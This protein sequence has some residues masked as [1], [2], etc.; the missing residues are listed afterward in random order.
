MPTPEDSRTENTL[1]G[2]ERRQLD[3]F[4]DDN[5]EELVEAVEGLTDEQA[6]RRLVPSLTTPMALVKH[7]AAAERV[8]FQKSLAGRSPEEIDGLADG[9]D[10][11]FELSDDDTLESVVAEYRAAVEESRRIA[12]TYELDDLALGNRRG[13]LTLRWIYMHMVE[14]LARHTGH[15]D[16]LREQILAA[17]A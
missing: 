8:W 7:A 1:T 12:A 14:E 5:R 17:D 13:P 2:D 9:S 4:L 10:I 16:I 3:A 6:R 15:A 11:S